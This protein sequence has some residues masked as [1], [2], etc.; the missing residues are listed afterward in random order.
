MPD[1]FRP[2]LLVGIGGTGCTIA[3]AV[4]AK[5][6][7]TEVGQRGKIAVVGVDTDENDMKRMKSVERQNIVRLSAPQTIYNIAE[8]LKGEIS[9][10]F[11]PVQTLPSEVR[12]M[13]LLDGAM[14]IRL[15]TRLGL[16]NAL[17]RAGVDRT[18]ANTIR[19]LAEHDSKDVKV[20]HINIMMVGSL[21]GATGS[22]SFVQVALILRDICRENNLGSS[23]RGLFLLPDVFITAGGLPKDQHFNVRANGYASLKELNA[24]NVAVTGRRSEGYER[25]FTYEYAPRKSLRTDGLPFD[26]ITLIDY[27]DMKG[28]NLSSS[29]ES[30]RNMAARAVYLQLFSP[31][32]ARLA[33]VTVNDAR[34]KMAA[35]A[36]GETELISG[37]GVSA[38]VYPVD[39]I[40]EYL[41]YSFAQENLAGDWLRLDDMYRVRVQ[42]YQ[43]QRAQGTTD[44]T[45]PDQGL[46]YVEDLEALANRERNAFFREIYEKSNPR[47]VDEKTAEEYQ[48][49]LQQ[50][51]LEEL[52][53]HC[54]T[55]FWDNAAL[56]PI[57]GRPPLDPSHLDNNQTIPDT[58][59]R[60][61]RQLDDDLRKLEDAVR[62]KPGD[63][64]QNLMANADGSPEAE[65]RPYHLQTYIIRGGPHL[66][67]VRYF[68]FQLRQ[69]LESLQTQL[70]PAGAYLKLFL[71]A[72]QF[73]NDRG[74][75]PT[76]RGTPK[77][78]Q[79]ARDASNP[80]MFKRM[81]GG[82][83]TF[84]DRYVDYYNTSRRHLI[85]FAESSVKLKVV[86]EL[87][88][89][90][91][92]LLKEINFLFL[93]LATLKDKLAA[94]AKRLESK[95]KTGSGAL[96]GNRY[97]YADEACK[98]ELWAEL[99]DETAGLRQAEEAN[100]TLAS[101]LYA[102]YREGRRRRRGGSGD[103]DLGRLFHTAI[104]DRFA[105]VAVSEDFR[106][107]YDF[108]VLTAIRREAEL[109]N[110][111]RKESE[112]EDWRRLLRHVIS[113][114]G[115][116]SEPFLSLNRI[117]SGQRIM[118]WAVH[119][120]IKEELNDDAEFAALF[121]LNEGEAPLVMSEFSTRE[122]LCMN[123]R[124]NLD[125]RDIRK[126]NPGEGSGGRINVHDVGPGS[127]YLAY[128]DMVDDI[129]RG[130]IENPDA[131]ASKY[132]TP[133]VDYRWHRPGMLP[134]IFPEQDSQVWVDLFKSFIIGIAFDI[135]QQRQHYG[136]T[137]T[138]FETAGRMETGGISRELVDG[139]DDWT[140]FQAL[141]ERPD[142]IRAAQT[143]WAQKMQSAPAK[144]GPLNDW[145]RGVPAVAA[146]AGPESRVLY[147]LL[148]ISQQ[149]R[150]AE[151]RDKCVRALVSWYADLLM[152][153]AHE[154]RGDM[155][156]IGRH[157]LIEDIL[158]E[159]R[160][161]TFASLRDAITQEETLRQLQTLH[162]QGIGDFRSRSADG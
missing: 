115:S 113:V 78:T 110:K 131:P 150:D 22:G 124:V 90:V 31:L 60:S 57:R 38:V 158:T 37:V 68:L 70:D 64:F 88:N 136:R 33:S 92:A 107:V 55:L 130:E 75:K 28:G 127:Y 6:I 142:L 83:S 87:Y 148:F 61:E 27:E 154:H 30:Y 39:D 7:A 15:L 159:E 114:V 40:R 106:S 119:P 109:A 10:W 47:V 111:N 103:T 26:S 21:A 141:G 101:S 58:V 157:Q 12:S 69:E 23:V 63:I 74:K 49:P 54:L 71:L 59:R 123:A 79:E 67:Q 151:R 2:T 133:H 121:T 149:R 155:E 72:N 139:G 4:H 77:I 41:T 65:W 43:D 138:F 99:R 116:Q 51:Y 42:R 100:K 102:K 18:F 25:A 8:Q 76:T 14:Q 81:F 53:S 152:A 125:L 5:A 98:R 89:E 35:A 46:A 144:D 17:S 94:E 120:S 156:S 86:T 11:P 143:F 161:K 132:F 112:R 36:Q 50:T 9:S 134:E 128:R 140:V 24:V 3:E 19:R 73:D 122:L 117:E 44:T 32:G 153:L 34:Q 93:E 162:E 126:L 97:V 118:F 84:K 137:K 96:E 13:T 56:K 146:L 147:R 20:G 29:L 52:L 129:I 66:V 45:P 135:L 16:H 82:G 104:I 62:D 1:E 91:D 145:F 105:R 160:E 95:H 80:G 85:E 108:S 48:K